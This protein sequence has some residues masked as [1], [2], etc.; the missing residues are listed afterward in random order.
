MAG[1]PAPRP[2]AGGSGQE[3]QALKIV[4]T[5]DGRVSAHFM[6]TRPAVDG[7]SPPPLEYGVESLAFTFAGD[8][9]RYPFRPTGQLH[10]SD[11]RFDIFSP[12]GNHV[13]LLQDRFGPYHVVATQRLRDYLLGKAGPDQEVAYRPSPQGFVPVHEQARWLSATEFE[14]VAG[15]E[16]PETIRHTI[17]TE[18]RSPGE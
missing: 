11:W 9:R 5:P 7:E 13:L 10:F 14:F 4:S 2:P 8:P 12:G 15:S 3:G 18:K 6:G 16:T 17:S 1:A